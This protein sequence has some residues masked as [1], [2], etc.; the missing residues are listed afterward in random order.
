MADE[1]DK[2]KKPADKLYGKGPKLEPEP[3]KGDTVKSEG[4]APK[5][6]AKKAEESAGD[7]KS[8]TTHSDIGKSG[9]EAKG[10]VMAGTDG[11]MTHH[12]Q[13]GERKDMHHRHMMEKESVH[14]RHEHE[15][16]MRAMGHGKESHEEM[17]TR[18]HAEIKAMNSRHEKEHREMGSRHAGAVPDAGMEDKD[19]GESGTQ[20]T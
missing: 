18:H 4:G 19:V 16:M 7:P 9:T 6:A 14:G 11:I 2:K 1:K 10:D 12:T 8:E 13:S 20:P 17:N 3:N 5:E 15:H